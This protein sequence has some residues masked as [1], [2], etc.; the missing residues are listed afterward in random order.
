LTSND[1]SYTVVNQAILNKR[2]YE[3][4]KPAWEKEHQSKLMAKVS[5]AIAMTKVGPKENQV[6]VAPE[7]AV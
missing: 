6:N 2:L 5:G 4:A 1:C 3:F 7:T